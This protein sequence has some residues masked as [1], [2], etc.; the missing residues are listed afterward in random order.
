MNVMAITNDIIANLRCANADHINKNIDKIRNIIFFERIYRIP[1]PIAR[2]DNN[3]FIPCGHTAIWNIVVTTSVPNKNINAA[4]IP[5]NVSF[6]YSCAIKK[7][8]IGSI[9]IYNIGIRIL[10]TR[11]EDDTINNG[12]NIIYVP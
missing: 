9:N 3:I 1:V 7:I 5:V 11:V 6:V 4:I 10:N 2:A 12:K 8:A